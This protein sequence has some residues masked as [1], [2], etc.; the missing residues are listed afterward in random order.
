MER[1]EI[2]AARKGADPNRP[3]DGEDPGAQSPDVARR[4]LRAYAELESLEVELLDLLAFRTAQMSE[5][6]RHEAAETNFPVLVSQLDRFHKRLDF[7]QQRKREVE[8]P[9]R[10]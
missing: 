5:D 1:P 6:A 3:I 7:W 10:Q 8:T 4:W 9:A 2:V